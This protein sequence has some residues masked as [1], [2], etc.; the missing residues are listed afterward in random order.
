M[1]ILELCSFSC[2]YLSLYHSM[3]CGPQTGLFSCYYVLHFC[4][5]HHDSASLIFILEIT[6]NR[7]FHFAR[8]PLN[9]IDYTY[10]IM[11]RRSNKI[12]LCIITWQEIVSGPKR[13]NH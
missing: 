1:S 12:K 2:S 13:A 4:Y 3:S 5:V 6:L 9:L 7:D 10:Q 11:T 8:C